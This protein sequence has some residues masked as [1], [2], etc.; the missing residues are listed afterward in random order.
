MN[1]NEAEYDPKAISSEDEE[2]C[3]NSSNYFYE[4]NRNIKK[5]TISKMIQYILYQPIC[6]NQYY[7]YYPRFLQKDQ[8]KQIC[9][10]SIKSNENII[11]NY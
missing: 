9:Q 5:S 3:N 2:K 1:E 7:A 4:N 11:L 6:F 10:V 8:I